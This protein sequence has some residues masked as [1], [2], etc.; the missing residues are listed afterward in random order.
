[1]ILQ[2]GLFVNMPTMKVAI[3]LINYGAFIKSLLLEE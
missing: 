1:M 2:V 3:P